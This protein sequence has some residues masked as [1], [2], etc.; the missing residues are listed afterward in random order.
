VHAD[1]VVAVGNVQR[2]RLRVR[3]RGNAHRVSIC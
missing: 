1:Q 2:R 3:P